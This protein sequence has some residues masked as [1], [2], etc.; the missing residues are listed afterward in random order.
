MRNKLLIL[1]AIM[2][3][4]MISGGCE[5]EQIDYNEKEV[6]Q[7]V[8]L[9]IGK[10]FSVSIAEDET[11]DAEY[12]KRVKS[13]E[14]KKDVPYFDMLDEATLTNLIEYMEN[15]EYEIVPGEYGINQGWGF[16]DGL[17]IVGDETREILKFKKK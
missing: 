15:N 5:Q 3:F 16:R 1:V 8:Q 6:N 4:V 9:Y 13:G 10:S 7:E 17:F 11:V 12:L 2:V 14:I